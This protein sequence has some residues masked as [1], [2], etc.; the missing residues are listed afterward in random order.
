[1]IICDQC[2][3]IER[4]SSYSVVRV[5]FFHDLYVVVTITITD[6]LVLIQQSYNSIIQKIVNIIL[7]VDINRRYI[8]Y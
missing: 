6:I 5:G 2:F 7:T 4:C 3:T 8:I 1:M